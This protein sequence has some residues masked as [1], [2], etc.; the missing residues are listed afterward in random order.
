MKHQIS[1]R[2]FGIGLSVVCFVVGGF[3]WFKSGSIPYWMFGI[4]FALGACSIG[5][6]QVFIPLN[7]LFLALSEK[8]S[9][10]MNHL[11]LGIVFFVFITPV[12]VIARIFKW[13]PM[14]RAA[15]NQQA[16]YWQESCGKITAK[17]FIDQF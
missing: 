10:F 7:C 12:F 3:L 16:T 6:P 5:I 14:G 2:N 1:D 8:I 15:K 4:S 11:I 9:V 13:D 17:Q